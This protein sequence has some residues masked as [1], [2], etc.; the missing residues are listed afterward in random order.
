MSK[1]QAG[2]FLK[3]LEKQ[4]PCYTRQKNRLCITGFSAILFFGMSLESLHQVALEL[5]SLFPEQELVIQGKKM[6]TDNHNNEKHAYPDHH[7]LNRKE[8]CPEKSDK[9]DQV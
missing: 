6:N 1:T 2:Y 9:R 4:E 8:G 3:S 5:L 7:T